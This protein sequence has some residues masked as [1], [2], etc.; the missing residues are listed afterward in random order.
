[1]VLALGQIQNNGIEQRV[2]KINSYT[3]S[4]IDDWKLDS[5][6]QKSN[7]SPYT[8]ITNQLKKT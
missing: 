5:H 4:E 6:M 7:V 2:P 8:E 3:C 1:M